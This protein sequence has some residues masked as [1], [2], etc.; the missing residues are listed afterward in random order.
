MKKSWLLNFENKY[1]M[2]KAAKS[3]KIKVKPKSDN[4]EAAGD[5]HG[6][7]PDDSSVVSTTSTVVS[8]VAA[9]EMKRGLKIMRFLDKSNVIE[10]GAG[11]PGGHIARQLNRD[12]PVSVN[13]N[14]DT[15]VNLFGNISDGDLLSFSSKRVNADEPDSH[16]DQRMYPSTG[17]FEDMTPRFGGVSKR[18]A[19]NRTPN[20]HRDFVIR[21]SVADCVSRLPDEDVGEA[22]GSRELFRSLLA[23]L[24][25]LGGNITAEDLSLLACVR[26]PPPY[27]DP[28]FS[29]I[30]LLI[31]GSL[32]G[33][34]EER[35]PTKTSKSPQKHA[36]GGSEAVRKTLLKEPGSILQYLKQVF[37][38]QDKLA[39]SLNLRLLYVC[40]LQIHP[41]NIPPEHVSRAIEFFKARVAIYPADEIARMSRAFTKIVQ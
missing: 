14:R 31:M 7:D 24:H 17:L 27:V 36:G 21:E 30:Y 5:V 25:S 19:V 37:C 35:S 3:K 6:R 20:V 13:I 10:C 16:W 23:D 41:S 38:V 28:V 18:R 40:I 1:R 32:P 33:D 4:A 34:G 29:Y 2:T 39:P 8:V 15:A 12:N 11:S 22:A 26:N 9:K